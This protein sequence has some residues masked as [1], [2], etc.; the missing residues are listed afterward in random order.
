MESL[1][2]PVEEAA[3]EPHHSGFARLPRVAEEGV[4]PEVPVTR[5]SSSRRSW[6]IAGLVA[7]CAAA[8]VLAIVGPW[9][10]ASPLPSASVVPSAAPSSNTAAAPAPAATVIL[11]STS[12]G[13]IEI[14]GR[15]GAI[16]Q[17]LSLGSVLFAREGSACVVI[18]PAVRACVTTGSLIR[19]AAVGAHRR[20]ELLGGKIAAEL[21][22]QRAG[23]SFGIMTR[24]GSAI[25]VGTAFSVE[26]PAG[27]APVVTRVLH[28]T[29]VVRSSAGA[30][31]EV[32]A[33]EMSS[34]RE[35]RRA[36][37]PPVEEARD[38]ALLREVPRI[39]G[40]VPPVPS[41]GAS[42]MAMPNVA[43]STSAPE[44][45]AA[46][47]ERRARGDLDGAST[48]Y[49][50]LLR[51]HGSSAEAHAALVPFGELRLAAG[52]AVATQEA[53]DSFDR[54]LKRGGSLEQEATFGRI[55]ALRALGRT[56]EE[57]KTIEAFVKRFPDA[58][59]ATSLGDRLRALE[60]R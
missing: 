46:A 49:R 41:S 34:M 56:A 9:R 3:F 55:R 20:I 51:R 37:L 59:L 36:V 52:G 33:H 42:A 60:G 30:E 44:L 48:A 21:D 27:N 50:D 8:S 17:A 32:S 47:R 28:G 13:L 18:E 43:P 38:L 58:P 14:D 24:E 25:A 15:A 1:V 53:L 7:T 57:R 35:L 23:T 12:G 54:Y 2:D 10:P 19:V 6:L 11:A 4:P 16:G 31:Q 26:V 45:L 40:A 39:V 22:R 5:R 29:V